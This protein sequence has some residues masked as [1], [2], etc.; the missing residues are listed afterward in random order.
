MKA[1]LKYI[2]D[3]GDG[4]IVFDTIAI[5][6]VKILRTKTGLIKYPRITIYIKDYKELNQLIAELNR[7]CKYEVQIVKVVNEVNRIKHIINI[8]K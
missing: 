2:D 7:K 4:N 5:R 3:L 8:F 1:I 6:N